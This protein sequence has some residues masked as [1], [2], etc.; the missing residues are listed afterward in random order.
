MLRDAL[1]YLQRGFSVVPLR[2]KNKRPLVPWEEYQR[3]PP[4]EEEVSRWWA[5]W[6]EANIGI[7]TGEVSGLVVVDVDGEKGLETAKRLG[8]PE[9]PTV[10]T[11]NG[12]HRYFRHPGDGEI[13]NFQTKPGLE[14]IDLRGDG[15][16]VV[17]PPSIHPS[18]ETYQWIIL[19]DSMPLPTI[20]ESILATTLTEKTPLTNLFKGVPEGERNNALARLTGKL[21]QEE[22][23]SGE[24]LLFALACNQLNKPPLSEKEVH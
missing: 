1:N 23:S 8:L 2:L 14:G 4:T 20:P 12:Y 10:K 9:G 11:G 18:G 5:K 19:L 15:G 17:A 16:Y 22:W 7:V 13:R 21:L 24:V 6:P 3:R